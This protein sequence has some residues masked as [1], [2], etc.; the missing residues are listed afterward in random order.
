M[1]NE[2]PTIESSL[3]KFCKKSEAF[4]IENFLVVGFGCAVVFALSY[5]CAGK[6][7]YSWEAGEYRITSL[8][9]SCFVF[10]ISGLT[11]KVE[12]L[13]TVVEH[14]FPF[15]YSLVA[16]N[17]LTT[18]L[19]FVMLNLPFITKDFAVGLAIFCTVPTT[20]GVGVA[21]TQLACGDQ[22]LS[23]F[24]T[25]VSNLLGTVTVPFLLGV[26]L[27]GSDTV[28]ID[29]VK[30]VVKMII[31]VLVPTVVGMATRRFIAAVPAFT[32]EYRVQLS[33]LSTFNL[34]MMEWMSLSTARN[35]LLEQNVGNIFL[36]VV[37]AVLMHI[38]YL[39]CNTAVVSK[40]LLNLQ[41]KQA[42]SVI[43]MASQKSSP[44]AL[45]V[46]TGLSSASDEEKG[47]FALPCIIGQM[48][49]ICIGSFL[50]RRLAQWVEEEQVAN[51]IAVATTGG[52]VSCMGGKIED[53]EGNDTEVESQR[54]FSCIH[55]NT[56]VEVSVVATDKEGETE[57][58]C[59]GE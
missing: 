49:Q 3:S 59:V 1:K 42:V 48:A 25:V 38:F 37:M 8:L 13:K 22:I 40:R 26:Y 56:A 16:I 36:V 31:S 47:L 52:G 50:T 24:L 17:F 10:F 27:S 57:K 15:V 6:L 11:L 39:C 5:P 33:M 44:V 4:V 53:V 34:I 21:L 28:H 18:L 23:L 12:D 32:K 19:S 30:L 41:P 58:L 29:P 55:S 43:I 35:S 9:N 51:N 20:L 46:I 45:A 14:K 54:T 2:S 7:F